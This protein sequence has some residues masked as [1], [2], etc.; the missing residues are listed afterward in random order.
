[1]TSLLMMDGP[2]SNISTMLNESISNN[3]SNNSFDGW[4]LD[5]TTSV[6][7]SLLP[8]STLMTIIIAT[9]ATALAAVTSG[10]NL[11]VIA[12]F[13]VDEQL[14]RVGNYFLL[15]LAIA[16]FAIGAVSM[17]LYT[18]YLLLDYWPL[19]KY[20]LGLNGAANSL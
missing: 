10:G 1:M 12:S 18:V 19:G 15:S 8:H 6:T 2:F 14:Q 9:V 20:K 17:P 3:N 11:L 7:P 13:R 16:D 4:L 5:S